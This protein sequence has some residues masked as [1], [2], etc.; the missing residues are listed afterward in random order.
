MPIV[1]VSLRAPK[2]GCGPELNA[3]GTWDEYE[4]RDQPMVRGLVIFFS[5]GQVRKPP[6][7]LAQLQPRSPVARLGQVNINYGG[8]ASLM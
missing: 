3:V 5:E 8:E 2:F 6:I 1:C 7:G 4:I